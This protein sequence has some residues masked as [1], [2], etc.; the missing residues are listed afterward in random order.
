M[1]MA[2]GT[3]SNHRRNHHH[4]ALQCG[5]QRATSFLHCQHR[6]RRRTQ[7]RRWRQQS[8]LC[9]AASVIAPA[10]APAAPSATAGLSAGR[11]T[12]GLS[13]AAATI[14]TTGSPREPG[15]WAGRLG[16]WC[17]A[18]RAAPSWP[19]LSAPA[20]PPCRGPTAPRRGGRREGTGVRRRCRAS[21]L[22]SR[23][24]LR[25]GNRGR[26]VEHGLS[27]YPIF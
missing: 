5:Q 4:H 11:S 27:L 2:A 14:G 12:R 17:A 22:C 24:R 13:S 23:P 18:S 3:H 10:I 20:P 8:A 1:K 25:P 26:E 16:P 19:R 7:W 21:R 9:L 6:R 15:A